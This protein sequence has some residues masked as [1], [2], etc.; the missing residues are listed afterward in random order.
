M[1]VRRASSSK[2]CKSQLTCALRSSSFHKTRITAPTVC[3]LSAS[4]SYKNVTGYCFMWKSSVVE[5]KSQM[6]SWDETSDLSR[7][8]DTQRP[9]AGHYARDRTREMYKYLRLL[10]WLLDFYNYHLSPSYI[11]TY[12]VIPNA[13]SCSSLPKRQFNNEHVRLRCPLL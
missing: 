7:W 8:L 11:K 3:A 5:N 10:P 1:C 2:T 6:R 9:I 13:G 12:G 4:A